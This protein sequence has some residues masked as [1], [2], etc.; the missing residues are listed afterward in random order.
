MYSLCKITI[1]FVLFSLN[2]FDD[3]TRSAVV[4]PPLKKFK[5]SEGNF[6]VTSQSKGILTNSLQIF[7]DNFCRLVG[8]GGTSPPNPPGAA[9]TDAAPR[10]EDGLFMAL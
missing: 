4:A 10:K 2:I 1:S 9:A 3:L 6:D 7:F 8:F 5:R